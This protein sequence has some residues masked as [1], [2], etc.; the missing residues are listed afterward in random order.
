MTNIKLLLTFY[1]IK[2]E[3]NIMFKTSLFNNF[4]EEFN[5]IFETSTSEPVKDEKGNY[6]IS[7]DV[8]GFNKDNLTV[9]LEGRNHDCVLTIKGETDSRK[10]FKQYL[11]SQY[12]EDIEASIIDGVLSLNLIRVQPE[13]PKRIEVKSPIKQ[14]T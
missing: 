6:K 2:M 12:V 9:D 11:I 10:Y 13:E 14:I 8:P 1:K 5:D 4:F 7:L 3:V